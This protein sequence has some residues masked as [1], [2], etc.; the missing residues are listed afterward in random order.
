MFILIG[1]LILLIFGFLYTIIIY[2][3]PSN[4]IIPEI[5]T[6]SEQERRKQQLYNN[7][8]SK[9]L[10]PNQTTS[11]VKNNDYNNYNNYSVWNKTTTSSNITSTSNTTTSSNITSTSNPTTTRNITSTSNPTT[12]SNITSTSNPTTTTSRNITSSSRNI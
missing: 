6:M 12:S 3:T 1:I 2:F 5:T 4:D 8:Y 10:Y 11:T 9:I 7:I